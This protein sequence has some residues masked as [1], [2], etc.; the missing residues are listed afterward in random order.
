MKKI[1]TVI[2]AAGN[3]TRFKNSKSKIFQDLAGLS[4]IEHVYSVANKISKDIIF[5]CNDNNIL[6]IRKLFPKSK[7]VIQKKQKGTADAILQ[8]KKY[9]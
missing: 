4:I 9:L 3:S 5:V 1:S 7:Y 2:L 6:I 8:A